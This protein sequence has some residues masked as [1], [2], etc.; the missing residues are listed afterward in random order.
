MAAEIIM[1]YLH[2]MVNSEK[3]PDDGDGPDAVCVLQEPEKPCEGECSLC[4]RDGRSARGGVLD[5]IG[6]RGGEPP[7]GARCGPR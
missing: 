3:R 6:E 1:G 5:R 4:G 7:V 2:V